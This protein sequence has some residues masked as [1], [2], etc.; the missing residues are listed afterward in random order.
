M[1]HV[2]NS[3]WEEEDDAWMQ[4][5]E[6][7]YFFNNPMESYSVVSNGIHDILESVETHDIV[8]NILLEIL[9]QIAV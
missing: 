4:E 3:L 8:Q 9:S 7:E 5:V 6:K 1:V 2:E